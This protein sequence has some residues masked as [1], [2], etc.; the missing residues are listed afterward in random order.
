MK[1]FTTSGQLMIVVYFINMITIRKRQI[2]LN[3]SSV[4]LCTSF[5]SFNWW[6]PYR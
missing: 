3:I 1:S 2:P 6:W 5:N 4:F